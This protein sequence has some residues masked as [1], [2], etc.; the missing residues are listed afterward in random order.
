MKIYYDPWRTE[1]KEPFGA[2]MDRDFV[3]FSITIAETAVEAAYLVIHKDAQEPYY[4]QLENYGTD[5]YCYDFFVNEGVGLYFYHFEIHLRKENQLEKIY[6]GRNEQGENICFL[7]KEAV[8]EY[9][10]TCCQ[11][12]EKAPKWYRDAVFYQIFP[13]RFFNGNPDGRVNAPKPNTFLYGRM[14]DNPLY[15][16]NQEGEILRWDFYGGNL[17]GI[18]KKIP[19]LKELGVTAI[20]LNPIF[21]ANSNHRYDTGDYLKIDE[22]LGDESD[23]NELIAALH[24]N[25]M[26]LVL[27]GVFNHVGKNSR[28]FDYDGSYGKIGAY[29]STE[30]PYF[31]WFKF[32]EYPE[33]Y[34]AWWGVKDLPEIAKENPDFQDF[35]YGTHSVLD[36]W[37]QLGV[38]GWRLDVA[39]ELPDYFIQGIRKN[40][41]RYKDKI[42]IGEVWEDASN[43]IA[44]Q[45]RRQY[46]L[47]DHLHSVMNY[48]LRTVIID[49][50][51]GDCSPRDAAKILTQLEENYPADIFYNNFNNIGT[52][53][54]P[55]I[56]S[57]LEGDKQKLDLAF[58][59]LTFMPGIPCIYYGDEAGLTGGKD[60]ENRKFFPWEQIDEECYG[61]CQRWLQMRKDHAL[62]RQGD[63]RLLFCDELLL[64]LRYDQENYLMAVFN[65]TEEEQ[66]LKKQQIQSLRDLPFSLTTLDLSEQ[67][68][69]PKAIQVFSGRF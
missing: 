27:D 57:E 14:Q 6:Y 50:L 45:Q 51:K 4:I 44:Y 17:K 25:E 67:S 22:I 53:D 26:H 29:Q 66:I 34:K 21:E 47:G 9:Q 69:H 60:P 8:H 12:K 68:I 28:Y 36:K 56:L 20:Y 62:L 58:A 37:N 49:F 32:E 43:K 1:H 33:K 7:S 18:I 24:E 35:I 61:S 64:I 63:F 38:D 2:V 42:L 31:D 41:D 23:F 11:K 40:L 59:F 52:H 55:R 65:P 46:I 19:Y 48:P 39:D 15:I 13:D 30:S 3:K 54:T 5:Y 16:K 10:L